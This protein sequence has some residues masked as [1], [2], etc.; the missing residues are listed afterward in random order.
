MNT[1]DHK[2]NPHVLAVTLNNR[3]KRLQ[4][5]VIAI[6]VIFAVVG[7]YLFIQD[8]LAL[9]QVASG[10][11]GADRS[12]VLRE[13]A[14]LQREILKT[15]V[16]VDRLRLEPT[17]E[18]EAIAQRYAFAKI[19]YK[20]LVAKRNLPGDMILFASDSLPL[21]AEMDEQFAQV[22]QLIRQLQDVETSEQRFLLL[23]E[24]DDLIEQI[25]LKTN[26]LF[27]VQ[28]AL[29]TSLFA[30]AVETITTSR[31]L[32]TFSGVILVIMSGL[33]V[34]LSRRALKVEQQDKDQLE[35]QVAERTAELTQTNQQLRHEITE[36][37]QA[38]RALAAAR[39]Q[40]LQASKLKSQ[41]LAKVS[42][43]LRTPLGAILG[44]SELLQD[45]I[46]GFL[47]KR[48]GDTLVKV[49]HSANYLTKLVNE[50]LDQAQFENGQAKL[51]LDAF[52]LTD[53]LGQ[54]E[55]SMSVLAQAKGLILTLI[56]EPEVPFSLNGDAYRL[57]QILMNLVSNAIKFTA[58]GTIQVRIYCPDA[59]HWAMQ[60]TDTGPGIPGEAQTQIFEPFWQVDGSP[61]RVHV[62]T[63]LGLSIV[64]QLTMLMDGQISLESKIGQGSTFTVL[65]PLLPHPE[66]TT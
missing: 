52:V 28:E 49:I 15:Q 66:K 59:L 64:K 36:R 23:G 16:I 32:L 63:G 44:Y 38:E 46:F 57:E 5:I 2:F 19:N 29:E 58:S 26:E 51:N 62:G 48:Q 56:V 6:L 4:L 50:L 13:V 40:A 33:V 61:T 24:L 1:P 3:V 7:V 53:M 17:G 22:D 27:I 47:S 65:F 18:T 45:G 37:K 14:N 20:N 39:D 25:E 34:Y 12:R 31:R 60:V 9:N 55:T 10:P 21:L 8:S 11:L 54:V 43:E 30:A 35:G 42:H 41:L